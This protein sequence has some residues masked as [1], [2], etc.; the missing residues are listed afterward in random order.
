MRVIKKS[1]FAYRQRINVCFL[2][3]AQK[4][5]CVFVE[6]AK[7]AHNNKRPQ[8][9]F[10]K[11][12]ATLSCHK[13]HS[14]GKQRCINFIKKT[15]FRCQPNFSPNVKSSAPPN[16]IFWTNSKTGN[17]TN[18]NPKLLLFV[19]SCHH[20]HEHCVVHLLGMIF[21]GM[22]FWNTFGKT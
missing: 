12:A 20:F 21:W 10:G 2:W 9:C 15:W 4:M 7:N 3:N 1:I 5:Q 16:I 22:I 11:C 17:Q 13:K 14:H 6:R 19:Y 8:T 18:F